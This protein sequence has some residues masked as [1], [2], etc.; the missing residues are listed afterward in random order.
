MKAWKKQNK[1]LLLC[2]TS[3][4]F[5]SNKVRPIRETNSTKVTAVGKSNNVGVRA[6][7]LQRTTGVQ[8]RS[9]RRW[10]DFT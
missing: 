10:G 2:V 4:I 7:S 8:R 1:K 5:R 3:V 9:P 6:R